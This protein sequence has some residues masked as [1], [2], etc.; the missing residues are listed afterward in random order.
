MV[1][2]NIT[3]DNPYQTLPAFMLSAQ[4]THLANFG[5]IVRTMIEKHLK[6]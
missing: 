3:P 1:I 5:N 2:V 6:K 4:P